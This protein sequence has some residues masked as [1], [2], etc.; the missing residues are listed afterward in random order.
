M[1]LSALSLNWSAILLMSRRRK[2]VRNSSK[3]A[4]GKI[5]NALRY[6]FASVIAVSSTLALAGQ[7]STSVLQSS[8]VSHSS[9]FV[10]ASSNAHL[11]K[12]QRAGIAENEG[13][14]KAPPYKKPVTLHMVG[15]STMSDKPM[16]SYPER[17]WGQFCLLYTSPSP[18]D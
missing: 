8:Y 15:D 12:E 17:G 3:P 6:S 10:L 4:T 11:A 14:V 2:G 13:S 18:R 5:F 7:G 16:L 1:R 9:T